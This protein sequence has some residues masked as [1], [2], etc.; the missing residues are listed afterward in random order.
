MPR[1]L[2][3]RRVTFLP[4]ATYFKPVGIPLEAL[5]EVCLSAEEAEAICLK[6]L[7]GLEQEEGDFLGVRI[8][9]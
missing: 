2:K 3:C 5:E 4:E 8:R 1:P 9:E 7:E 6:D